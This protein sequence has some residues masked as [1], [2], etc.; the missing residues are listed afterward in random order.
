M[1]K[2]I[3]VIGLTICFLMIGGISMFNHLLSQFHNQRT[4]AIYTIYNDEARLIIENLEREFYSYHTRD[5]NEKLLNLVTEKFYEKFVAFEEID[6]I[7]VISDI[8]I[9]EVRVLAYNP[10]QIKVIGCGFIKAVELTLEGE[11]IKSFPERFFQKIYFFEYEDETW[12]LATTY[13]FT[14]N[15]GGI[16]DWDYVSD[17]EKELI[18]D[19]K[20]YIQENSDCGLH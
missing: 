6:T 17:W 14:D 5:N 12:K 16:R 18:G 8:L 19:G 7:Y 4:S 13:D 15:K 1:K 9:Q 2:Y 20:V 10:N 11:Y 3:A